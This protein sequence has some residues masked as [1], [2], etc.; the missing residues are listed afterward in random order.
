MVGVI[1]TCAMQL[2]FINFMN[3]ITNR[4]TQIIQERGRLQRKYILYQWRVDGVT[5]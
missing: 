2:K 1:Q 4:R 3:W 5:V